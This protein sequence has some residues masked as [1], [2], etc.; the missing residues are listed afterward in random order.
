MRLEQE[1][2]ERHA[3]REE[4]RARRGFGSSS[5]SG[6]G[7]GGGGSRGGGGSVVPTPPRKRSGRS[8]TNPRQSNPKAAEEEGGEEEEGHDYDYD[9]RDDDGSLG[10]PPPASATMASRVAALTAGPKLRRELS[11]EG[12]AVLVEALSLPAHAFQCPITMELMTDPV[13]MLA[14]GHTYEKEA[15]ENWLRHK[16]TSPVTGAR[17]SST[18]MV[19]NYAL[20]SSIE[21]F[22]ARRDEMDAAERKWAVKQLYRASAAASSADGTGG[23]GSGG[24][25]NRPPP[26]PPPPMLGRKLTRKVEERGPGHGDQGW[27]R[28]E[29]TTVV[30]EAD[31]TFR[32]ASQV[33]FFRGP[34]A[35]ADP[36]TRRIDTSGKWSWNDQAQEVTLVGV[37]TFEQQ[38]TLEEL[39]RLFKWSWT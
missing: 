15:I 32:Y 37:G 7:G 17:L 19:P 26:P 28:S 31:M 24:R 12:R 20:R 29:E 27:R 5:S 25:G 13:I 14:D 33:G 1:R 18:E 8:R 16:Q 6:G 39:R 23:G 2:R 9:D 11:D 3:K 21:D 4:E 30:F 34:G 35:A 38:Y 22:K 10:S 36:D